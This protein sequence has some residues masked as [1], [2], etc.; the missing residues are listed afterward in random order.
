MAQYNFISLEIKDKVATVTLN[1][2]ELHNAFNDEMISE[3]TNAFSSFSEAKDIYAV[4]LEAKG[5]SFCAGADLNWM[6][7]MVDYSLEENI[8]DSNKLAKMFKTIYDCPKV[9]IAKIQ[10]SVYG[11]GLGL[12]SVSDMSVSVE[13]AGFCFSEVKLGLIPAVI[14]PFVLRKIHRAEANRYF[15]SAEVFNAKEAN[16]IGLISEVVSSKGELDA[17]VEKWLSRLS[18]NGKEAMLH[19]KMLLRD[20]AQEEYKDDLNKSIE[21]TTKKI[22]ERR[23][24][25]EGQRLM[26]G[27]LE[28]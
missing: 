18:K 4:V 14:S 20:L 16:R 26:K 7:S 24:S 5:K 22:A 10:G 15:L 9:I 8:T 17:Q 28:K 27:F 2:P 19:A 1:R 25:E 3:L 23:I 11:G 21:L 13:C 6:K 12:V